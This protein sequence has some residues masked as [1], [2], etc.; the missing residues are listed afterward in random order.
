MTRVV[1]L[2]L[3]M[4]FFI[5][6]ENT[7]YFYLDC[8]ITDHRFVCDLMTAYS[9]YINQK[10]GLA[11]PS[12]IYA[13]RVHASVNLIVMPSV[14]GHLVFVDYRSQVGRDRRMFLIGC[15]PDETFDDASFLNPIDETPLDYVLDCMT[16]VNEHTFEMACKLLQVPT[17][18]PC[19]FQTHPLLRSNQQSQ[20]TSSQTTIRPIRDLHTFLQWI[21][22]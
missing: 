15:F 5:Y 20:T 9:P 4:E 14:I 8:P 7:L 11:I 10:T 12:T 21:L 6:Y 17:S 16:D 22:I 13:M 19:H 1:D 2:F 3:T 18:H